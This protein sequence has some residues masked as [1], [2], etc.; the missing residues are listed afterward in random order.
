MTNFFDDALGII[1]KDEVEI[2]Q[3][4]SRNFATASGAKV[5]LIKEKNPP[6]KSYIVKQKM[7]C[8]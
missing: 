3:I 6:N 8:F 1:N 4:L 5:I 2:K 7:I